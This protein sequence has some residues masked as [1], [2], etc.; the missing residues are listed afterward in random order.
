MESPPPDY[1]PTPSISI[2]ELHDALQRARKEQAR[3]HHIDS[4]HSTPRVYLEHGPDDFEYWR[5]TLETVS[6]SLQALDGETTADEH[7][8]RILNGHYWRQESNHWK[9]LCKE[10]LQ[11]DLAD[12]ESMWAKHYMEIDS[13]YWEELRA[14]D[15]KDMYE[16]LDAGRNSRMTETQEDVL[17]DRRTTTAD[18][19]YYRIAAKHWQTICHSLKIPKSLASLDLKAYRASIRSCRYWQAEFE[20]MSETLRRLRASRKDGTAFMSKTARTS[21]TRIDNQTV[22]KD[23]RRRS[24]RIKGR[25]GNETR[26]KLAKPQGIRRRRARA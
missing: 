14:L 22:M 13:E 10:I 24:K 8:A 18:I 3:V 21:N 1:C 2:E 17:E 15:W 9:S 12:T 19:I 26:T 7:R 4:R 25:T 5:D 11:A 16:S 6:R 20:G 23:P